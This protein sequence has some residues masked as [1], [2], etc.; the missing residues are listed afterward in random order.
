MS[1][2][3]VSASVF[4]ILAIVAGPL[5]APAVIH[6]RGYG[7]P[8][9][10]MG[11]RL[12]FTTWAMV[13]PGKPD[14]RDAAGKSAYAGDWKAGPYDASFVNEDAPWGIR[15]RVE[16]PQRVHPV[17]KMEAPWEVGGQGLALDSILAIDGKFRMWGRCKTGPCIWE[18]T[19]GRTWVRP[20]LGLV[21]FQGSKENNLIP[22]SPGVVW[23]DPVAPPEERYKSVKKE[24][25]DPKLF[26]E[27]KKRRPFSQMALE[28][29][30]GR[31]HAIFGY[32][33]ADG[34]HWKKI[35]DPL[36]VEVCDTAITAYYDQRLKEYV[37]YTRTYMVPPRAEGYPLEHTRWHQFSPR[38]AI[39]RTASPKFAEFPLSEV[40]VD[41]TPDMLPTDTWYTACHT[42]I[43]GM[44]EGHLMF[45]WRYTQADDGGEIDLLTSVEGKVW[46]RVPGSP[47]FKITPF[48]NFDSGCLMACPDLLELP[49]GD[50]AIGYLALAYPHKYPRGDYR[51]DMG[52]L[53]WPKGRLLALEATERGE[54]TMLG[55]L[56][57]GT[58]LK[59]NADI[60]R[61]GSI[62]VEAADFHGK[63][64]PG[65][66]FAD[67]NLITGNQFWTT[68]TWK[69]T[70][71]LGVKTGQ[72]VVL[73]FKLNMAKLYGIEFE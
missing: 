51:Y 6:D 30:P 21:E 57:P 50:W 52:M 1:S 67:A 62:L 68:V 13:R 64:L 15:L 19:D 10:L 54:F 26:E 39:G 22:D 5:P 47:I 65:R 59:I 69:D 35:E 27:Y 25:F 60:K 16:A 33:S 53:V 48:G 55:I 29:D 34:Y 42:T 70:D 71:D 12:V 31:I 41:S 20:N 40:I 61:A 46:G 18:S 9:Q 73:R 7:E 32:T 17:V 11:K 72:P 8:V 63:A 45:P 3:R 28:P 2:R 56:A 58:K 24:D 38:R 37:I 66:S 36:S 44:P 43:P 23:I 49:D 4:L 14:W